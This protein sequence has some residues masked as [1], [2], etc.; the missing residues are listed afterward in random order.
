[1]INAIISAELI[2][3]V[4]C[5]AILYANNTT[6]QRKK[7]IN[8]AF[9][10]ALIINIFC[11]IADMFSYIADI[12]QLCDTIPV[13]YKTAVTITFFGGFVLCSAFYQY[14]N[15]VVDNE[16]SRASKIIKLLSISTM[17]LA[18]IVLIMCI[19]GKIFSVSDGGFA[20]AEWYD[21]YVGIQIMTLIAEIVV[22]VTLCHHLDRRVYIALVVYCVL[23]LLTTIFQFVFKEFSFGYTASSLAFL[24]IYLM[25]Q[26]DRMK[27]NMEL[28]RERKQFRDA[29]MQNALYSF[30]FDVTDGY[31][32]KDFKDAEGNYVMKKTGIELPI[33]Y[34]DQFKAYIESSDVVFLDDRGEYLK[35]SEG[36]LKLYKKRI[37]AEGIK[38]YER[39]N[40][41]YMHTLLLFS[42][43]KLSG[44]IMVT[45]ICSDITEEERKRQ[46][47]ESELKIALENELQEKTT[48]ESIAK[49]Y[50]SM[51]FIDIQKEEFMDFGTNIKVREFTDN[52]KELN[53]Q[54]MMW[55][56]MD[57]RISDI[58]KEMMKRFT[59]FSTLPKRIK[60]K[61]GIFVEAVSVSEHWM[62]FGFIRIKDSDNKFLFVSQDIDE[63]KRNEEELIIL[64]NIDSLT[65]IYNRYAYEK[66]V[67]KIQKEGIGN[68]LWY[69]AVDLNGLKVTNDT[70]G[71]NAGD[72]LI[73]ATADCLKDTV[74][75]IGRAFRIGGD[76]FTAIFRGTIGECHEVID[77][78]KKWVDEWHGEYS[79]S[80][81][82]SRGI[83]GS[84]EMPKCTISDLEKEADKR[85]YIEKRDY[86]MKH[87]DRRRST[88]AR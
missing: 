83:V 31:I 73:K 55:G 87:D 75:R 66:Y 53:I 5:F 37:T 80:F 39:K 1:M 4:V 77:N 18:V 10:F 60:D 32:R 48:I 72:E 71:H 29:L 30:T 9:N 49:I 68:D 8:R 38:H 44:H 54:D 36:L 22:I 42:V 26:S 14:L 24:F 63:S 34:D 76:E 27:K 74:S 67:E 3:A 82:F 23:P 19:C 78:M 86:H 43:D 35:T 57:D 21:F 50:N 40:D 7:P 11:T 16:K 46:K 85:M 59:D 70:I 12:N 58:H 45:S 2:S 79:D 15:F 25:I 81:S 84:F 33:S 28:E 47:Q 20:V 41:R 88:S 61:N 51:H 17:I 6:G 69:I 64:S 62:R 52:H 56:V 13:I 65:G